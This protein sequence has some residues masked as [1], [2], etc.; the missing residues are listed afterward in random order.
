MRPTR[1][2]RAPL[3]L[4]RHPRDHERSRGAHP[5]A[6]WCAM[7]AGASLV[8]TGKTAGVFVLHAELPRV[9]RSGAE[10]AAGPAR[11]TVHG[12]V[13]VRDVGRPMS[14]GEAD[15]VSVSCDPSKNRLWASGKSNTRVTISRS[16]GQVP[17]VT[18]LPL[19]S[20]TF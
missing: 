6:G 13:T 11:G 15:L 9:E 14:P 7:H 20:V 3:R 16:S 8:V 5:V 18:V 4:R 1:S 10:R 2:A 19:T 17:C 12:R